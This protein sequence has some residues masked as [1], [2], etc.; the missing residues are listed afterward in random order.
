MDF[1]RE[2]EVEPDEI[3]DTK[4]VALDKKVQ[5]SLTREELIG[6]AVLFIIAGYP[7]FL[8]LAIHFRSDTSANATQYCLYELA[9]RP[10][11]QEKVFEEMDQFI[12]AD[13]DINYTNIQN[14]R[15]L[16]W[17]IKETLRHHPLVQR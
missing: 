9:K 10:K 1:L 7:T 15:Y 14:L 5:K 12:F 3:L 2:A 17:F 13:E 8:A 4:K 11:E 6:M 16:D